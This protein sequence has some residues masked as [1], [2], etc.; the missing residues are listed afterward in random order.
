MTASEIETAPIQAP[1]DTD[2]A[3]LGFQLLVAIARDDLAAV[4]AA[5]DAGASPVSFYAKGDGDAYPRYH[6][7]I[8]DAAR[9]ANAEI[10]GAIV[11]HLGASGFQ[12]PQKKQGFGK[13][14]R[15]SQNGVKAEI[16]IEMEKPQICDPDQLFQAVLDRQS[17]AHLDALLEN[18]IKPSFKNLWAAI[19]AGNLAAVKKLHRVMGSPSLAGRY[20]TNQMTALGHALACKQ[21]SIARWIVRAYPESIRDSQGT[22]QEFPLEISLKRGLA[23]AA[24]TIFRAAENHDFMADRPSPVL[25]LHNLPT[26]WRVRA[27]RLLIAKAVGHKAASIEILC[28]YARYGTKDGDQTVLLFMDKLFSRLEQK[29]A[30]SLWLTSGKELQQELKARGIN[31]PPRLLIPLRVLERLGGKLGVVRA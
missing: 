9:S 15:P 14:A 26:S 6:Y 4:Q 10:F 29:D 1:R 24:L 27:A 31:P 28:H 23:K 16:E 12:R 13:F 8:F 5:L 25:S 19:K 7:P 20:H 30:N 22:A 2:R 11:R 18:N 3:A 21:Q 17:S